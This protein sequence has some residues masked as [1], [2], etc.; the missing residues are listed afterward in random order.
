M[1]IVSKRIRC[2]THN[3]IFSINIKKKCICA[4]G[5]NKKKVVFYLMDFLRN[6]FLKKKMGVQAKKSDRGMCNCPA[7][8]RTHAQWHRTTPDSNNTIFLSATWHHKKHFFLLCTKQ[9]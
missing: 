1:G 2:I 5:P 7:P 9:R 3:N 8:E 4:Y 6:F